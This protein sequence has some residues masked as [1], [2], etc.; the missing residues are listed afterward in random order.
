MNFSVRSFCRSDVCEGKDD[1]LSSRTVTP[2]LNR[3]VF[4]DMGCGYQFEYCLPGE[5]LVTIQPTVYSFDL[6][7]LE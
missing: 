4:D 6:H 2:F 5:Y 1:A 3:K 7:W